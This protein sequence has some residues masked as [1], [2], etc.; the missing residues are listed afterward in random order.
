MKDQNLEKLTLEN[1]LELLQKSRKGD[2][3][4]LEKNWWYKKM[5]SYTM[6]NHDLK[7]RL[8]H[9]IDALSSLS[10]SKDKKVLSIFNEYFKD[11]ELGFIG[12]GL[13]KLS[14]SLFVKNIKK[15]VQQ[16]AKIFITGANV[17]EALPVLRKNWNNNLAFSIDILNE[18]TLS[19]K[20][21][22]DCFKQYMELIDTLNQN[23]KTW[24]KNERLQSDVFNS[25]PSI[26]VSVKATSI[27]SQIKVEAWEYSKEE[28]KKRLRPL[29][30]KAV[31]GFIFINLDM[32]QY[33]YKDLLLETFKELLLEKEFKDYPHFGIVIQTYLRDSFEDL[34]DLVRFSEQRGQP[35]TIRL[36]KGAYWDSEVLLAKQ[37]N[38]PI[39]VYTHK[40]E[41]DVNFEECAQYLFKS[42]S[43]I[44]IAIGSHNIRSIAYCL[45]LHKLYPKAQMEFQIL[46]GMGEGLSQAL[47][48]QNYCVR[49]YST[50]GEL[51]PGMSYLVR[52]LLE[53]SA[54]QSF[55]LSS[56]LKTKKPEE[57]LADPRKSLNYRELKKPGLRD[58]RVNSLPD[59]LLADPDIY[60]VE[61]KTKQKEI[62]QN[63][64]LLDFSQK[65]NRDNFKAALQKVKKQFPL[66]VPLILQG[67]KVTSAQVL[68]RE[69]PNQTDQII[70]YSFLASREQAEQAVSYTSAF[71][72]EWKHSSPQKRID[73]TKKLAVLLQ[74][75]E[76]ELAAL[77][78]FEVGKTWREA[79][80]D[81]A[82]AIDF[83][84]YYALSYE[85]LI[86]K[87]KTSETAGEESFYHYEAIGPTAVIS[88]W[89]FPLA[90]LTGM[91]IAPLL[92]GNTVLIKSAEQSSLT[93]L[94]LAEL[95]LESGFPK[96]SFAF[97]PGRGE[98]IGDYL[99][100]HPKVSIVSFTGSFEVGA[101]IIQKTGQIFK[102]QKDIKK[103]I[104]E[105]GGKNT[106]VVDSS[107]DLD[108]AIHGVLDSA[109]GF[110]GQKC[111]AC[112]RVVVVE[113]VYNNFIERFIPA[114]QS[115][116]IG[117]TEKPEVSLGPLVDETSFKRIKNFTMQEESQKLFANSCLLDPR[118][119]GD[120]GFSR[121]S[122]PQEPSFPRRR[123]STPPSSWIH[124]PVIYLVEDE[125]ADLMQKEFFAPVLAVFKVKNLDEAI[126]QV[127]KTAF[128]LTAGF[129][130]RQPSH[131][132]KFKTLVEVG[133]VYINRNCTGA[134][135]ER[136]P[137][138]GRK[139][140]G[141]G[142]KTGGPEYLKQFL[143]TKIL[144]ENKMRRGF[145]PELFE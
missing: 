119:H 107:A 3:V 84:S 76:L 78:V 17:E 16:V 28:I 123:E 137:F 4:F 79:Q 91:S 124:P 115:L 128:G 70:S 61:P 140:S 15:Q 113:D 75:K 9:F 39:P 10:D 129:Y 41:T 118:I 100:S 42:S 135:V 36:V 63:H 43:I 98:E 134:L 30:C 121:M 20:E 58:L 69:N 55:V 32:E 64:P 26:N 130:S 53:N 5:L 110:Q 86:Q 74:E 136:H 7:T 92:C 81:V 57:L 45:A 31:Q 52:R 29:Y 2:S 50:I 131:I 97:L 24:S 67:K 139:M 59:P 8:F 126:K 48:A 35:I 68:K 83:C 101:Q 93:G 37:K 88:P 46:Y 99:V 38:W 62:F 65:E 145:S 72:E 104:V 89:N 23:M 108:E 14:P 111:S 103:C 96:E 34:Q 47:L 21:A 25:L 80:A 51:I 54:N 127:N 109:F 71:F 116:I 132:E 22:Q 122:F 56:F 12:A 105:M 11:Q 6:N 82:E 49:L 13:G 90:I 87:K 95:L 40:A 102:D 27:F 117:N 144:T 1:G 133:N 77:Q 106:I 138:G 73:R 142:S 94:K 44:K 114:V 143:H 141:L 60:S 112:S 125:N 120:D 66:E 18:A 85:K 33:E 19:E